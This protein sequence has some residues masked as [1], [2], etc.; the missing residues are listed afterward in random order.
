MSTCIILGSAYCAADVTSWG[1][2]PLTLRIQ[3]GGSGGEVQFWKH[4]SRNVYILFRHGT[5]HKYLP[6]QIPYRRQ[7]AAIHSLGVVF[8]LTVSSVGIL[9]K[10]LPLLE[11][12]LLTDI[13]MPTNS[14]PDGSLHKS[15]ICSRIIGA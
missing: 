1:Y 13:I 5:P 15:G 2:T 14:L 4:A 3:H 8:V 10:T 11:P 7:M 12:F 9:D 6:N